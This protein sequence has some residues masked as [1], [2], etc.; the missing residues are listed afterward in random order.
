MIG[1][2]V[3]T[4]TRGAR[5]HASAVMKTPMR[6]TPYS[7]RALA[8]YI[9]KLRRGHSGRWMPS[10]LRAEIEN[11]LFLLLRGSLLTERPW[12]VV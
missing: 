8:F 9:D 5:V 4:P 7:S 2:V 3:F 12:I 6:R 11:G 1:Y 10:Q